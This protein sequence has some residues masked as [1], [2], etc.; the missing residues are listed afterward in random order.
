MKKQSRP[1][2]SSVD[3]LTPRGIV[4]E[5]DRHV[6]G[7]TRAKRALAVALRNRRRRRQLAPELARDVQPRN[8]ILIGP[9]G[10]GKTELA[11]RVARLSNAPFLKVEASK[12]TEVGYVGR[13]VESIIDELAENAVQMVRR[14]RLAEIEKRAQKNAEERLLDLLTKPRG[15]QKK[16][17]RRR[18]EGKR[19]KKLR[20]E[21]RR[22]LRAGKL[23]KRRIELE[24]IDRFPAGAE[25]SG[26]GDEEFEVHLMD[27]LGMVNQ[28]T[29]Q[30]MR[31]GEA[32][33]YLVQ[34]EEARL[35]DMDQVVREALT[36][37]QEDGIV[38]VDE[39]DK[40]AGR[41]SGQGPQ[42]SREGVQR[43]L[44]PLVEGTS[45][46]T[47]YGPVR[48]DHVLFIAAGAFHVSRPADL[49][50]ELQ[51]R[52]P[53]RVEME[54]LSEADL[55][56]ILTEPENSLIRQ[57]RALLS[58]EGIELTFTDGALR[59]VARLADQVNRSTENI[60]ARRL[61][62]VLETLLEE[63]SFQ[64]PDS[65]EKRFVVDEAYVDTRLSDLVKDQD[66]SR[67]IL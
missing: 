40:V 43:N 64:G 17:R 35:V 21:V 16:S 63:I 44:L 48:T 66:L 4:A 33:N 39:L 14:G 59:R 3:D 67:Y 36:R 18:L 54:S 11:R 29:V 7:Q 53:V 55:V 27:L 56:R 45:V 62:T 9:T 10:V 28:P 22:Q 23:D 20:E 51:G 34:E 61:H 8:L 24:V 65:K 32:I 57:Y 6:V 47:R 31:V 49:I 1:A 19:G 50:P 5:L 41:E 37:V 52:F 30:K 25:L 15:K 46:N 26:V 2:P 58:A 13:D 12:F 38:F 60:G 42:V